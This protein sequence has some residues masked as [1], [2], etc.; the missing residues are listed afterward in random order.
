MTHNPFVFFGTPIVARDTLARLVEAGYVPSL[1]VTSPDAPKGRGLA[2]TPSETRVWAEEHNIPVET[3]EKLS[4]EYIEGLVSRGYSYALVVAYGKILPQ[5]LID[6]FPLGVLNVHYSLLPAYRGASPVETALL[7]GETET[8][9]SVQR[10]VFKL[11]AGDVLSSTEVSILP[12]ETTK[13]LR[14][15]LVHV[16]ADLLVSLLPAF[17]EGT[18]VGVPQ[19]ESLVT[20]SGKLKKEDGKLSLLGDANKNWNTY[21]AF[22]ESPGTHFFM[23]KADKQLRVKLVSAVF[24]NS[25]FVPV[26]VVPEGKKEMAYQDLLNTGWVPL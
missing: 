6:A 21:R 5:S 9:V 3:P 24:E 16:G 20:F 23:S 12:E 14:A 10:M 4:P 25:M 1:V 19:D 26:R 18:L 8:G 13:E 11:D 15:R 22:A 7:N 17:E 2:L